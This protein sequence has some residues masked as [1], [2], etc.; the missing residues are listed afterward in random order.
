MQLSFD[1]AMYGLNV[2]GVQGRQL[3]TL[4]P[5]TGGGNRYVP[6]GQAVGSA[7]PSGQ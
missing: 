3:E 4:V 5:T 2:P 1:R 7:V 6:F